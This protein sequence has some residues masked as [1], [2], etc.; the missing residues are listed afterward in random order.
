MAHAA[1]TVA[2]RKHRQRWSNL[3][4]LAS[5][6]VV[7][8]FVVN[9]QRHAPLEVTLELDA[10]GAAPGAMVPLLQIAAG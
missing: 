6:Q 7:H 3:I 5:A 2:A 10:L 4:P 9:E 1:E 8:L